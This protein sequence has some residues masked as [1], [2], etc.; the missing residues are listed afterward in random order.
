MITPTANT[1]PRPPS[2]A[3]ELG[4]VSDSRRGWTLAL[5]SIAFFMVAL[6]AL[7]VTTALPAIQRDLK[8]SVSTL[9]WTVNAYNLT[10]AAGTIT[11][12]ALGD[13]LGRRRVFV[14]GLALFTA[15]SAACAAAPTVGSLLAARAAQGIGAATIMPLSL[16]ILTAAFPAQRRGAI[17]GAWGG[18]AGLAVA[19]GPLVGGAIT[20]GIDWHWIFW[21]NVPIGLAA[22]VL[23]LLRVSE[24]HGS[25]SRLDRPGVALVTAG[26]VSLV[27]GLVRANAAGWVSA[28]VAAALILG[29][30]LIAAFVAWQRRAPEPMLPPRLFHSRAFVAANSTGF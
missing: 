3:P 19:A 18:I 24:N 22:I 1:G 14:A 7:A 20:Q 23:S 26:A 13:R 5:T 16:T 17:I 15:A 6:D 25:A 10:Y 27:W 8:A 29:G 30:G 11:A 12:A 28:E 4:P 9:G 2:T 21:I